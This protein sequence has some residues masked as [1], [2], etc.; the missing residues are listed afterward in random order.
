MA[1]RHT[2]HKP[3][4]THAAPLL[5]VSGASC[6]RPCT[7]SAIGRLQLIAAHSFVGGILFITCVLVAFIYQHPFR[8]YNDVTCIAFRWY[9][10]IGCTCCHSPLYR[11]VKYLINSLH[12]LNYSHSL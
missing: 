6:K 11:N 8:F 12:F 5:L 10:H 1:L 7:S 3:T 4:S 9:R 2:S